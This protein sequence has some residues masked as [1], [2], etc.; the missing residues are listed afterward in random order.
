MKAA[1]FVGPNEPIVVETVPDP[2][3]G[4]GEVVVRVERCGIC[5]S[6]LHFIH[7]E[8]PLPVLPPLTMGHEAAGVVAAV[9]PDVPLWREGERVALMGGKAC[10][11][12]SRCKAGDL[13]GCLDPRVMGVHHDGAWA[14]YVAVPWYALI[15]VPDGV[16]TDHAAIACDA[17]ST[18]FAALTERGGLRPGESVG[19]WG[20]GGLG[21][22]AV[23]IARIAGAAFV[24]AVDPLPAAR[25]RALS[26]GA[27]L[28]LDPA[29]DV[30]GEVRR[31]TGGGGLDLAL[32]LVGRASAVKQAMHCLTR[33]GRVVLVGQ[34]LEPLDAGPIVLL[35][36]MGFGLLG[37]L[38]YAKRH[39]EQVLELVA[40]GR[41]DLSGSISGHVPLDGIN[42]G[43]ARLTGKADAPVR[44]LVS[45]QAAR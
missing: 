23:Q 24:V 34:S 38:G 30:P 39:V 28:A 15:P 3:P 31:A 42:E 36:F 32:D 8:L 5:A 10:L 33:R 25:D 35:S 6:D 7:G 9:G 13:E 2:S 20:I 16:K 1:R 40:A 22:H 27:D 43:V 21:T 19:L 17:V 45:P 26:L 18:P 14:E 11:A 37:H 4:P 12:C 44:L 41:L 29:D